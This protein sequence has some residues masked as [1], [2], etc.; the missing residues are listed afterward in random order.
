MPIERV[1]LV[2]GEYTNYCK[3]CGVKFI[4][5]YVDED[6]E[7]YCQIV[8]ICPYCGAKVEKNSNN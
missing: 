5:Y 4:V 3:F 8:D 6:N 2:Y 7:M 1:K